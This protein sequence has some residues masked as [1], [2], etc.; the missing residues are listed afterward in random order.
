MAIASR[1]CVGYKHVM[2]DT[3]FRSVLI[4]GASSG[5]GRAVALRLAR[6]G[7]LITVTGRDSARLDDV[8]HALRA[9]GADVIARQIDVA[10][11]AGMS[12]LIAAAEEHAPLDL[13]IAN[14]G[15]S[16]GSGA[17][18]ADDDIIRDIFVV[19]LAGVLNTV[20]PAATRMRA[21]RQGRIA[22]VSSVAGIRG[23]PTAPAYSASKV[24]VRAWGDA[25]RPRLA[26]DGVAL[27]MI[28]PGFVESR[29]TAANDFPM[30]MLMPAE[31]AAEIIVRGLSRGK[32]C[33]A[34]PWQTIWAMRLLCLL[35]GRLFD[36]ILARGPRKP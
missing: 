20:L 36:A 6:P 18:A 33:I 23:L 26:E 11:R 13:V 12:A 29:I 22:I 15:I 32:R 35:P 8:S 16:S 9:K 4:T 19:N 34:F 27:T 24:A 17:G 7:V 30:P 25:I 3:Q 2:S 5:I 10:D 1:R 21:R 31:T 28:L 14:A